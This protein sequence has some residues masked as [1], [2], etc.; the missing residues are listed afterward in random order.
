MAGMTSGWIPEP[1]L[2]SWLSLTI[3]VARTVRVGTPGPEP[4]AWLRSNRRSCSVG[5]P[6]VTLLFEPTPV[7][8]P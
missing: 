6:S 8:R 4:E 5:F 3:M 1:P 7:V 2:S